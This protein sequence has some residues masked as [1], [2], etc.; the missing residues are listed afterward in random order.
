M[1]EMQVFCDVCGAIMVIKEE[2]KSSIIYKCPIC[3]HIKEV[4]R[5]N[6]EKKTEVSLVVGNPGSVSSDVVID[7]TKAKKS[8]A[9]VSVICPKCGYDKA[10]VVIMQTRAADEPPTRIYHCARCG[11]TWREY[12]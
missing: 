6:K 9:L 11:H 8:G 2:K 7:D 5:S 10:Y 12:S 4:K 3:G 1:I